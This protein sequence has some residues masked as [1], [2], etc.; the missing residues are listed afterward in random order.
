[1]A[2]G[3]PCFKTDQR[4]DR[5]KPFHPGRATV[6]VGLSQTLKMSDKQPE[7]DAE[8]NAPAEKTPLYQQAKV[9]DVF[10][11]ELHVVVYKGLSE[12]NT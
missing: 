11:W 12:G 5:Q 6:V 10:R 3:Q 8:G 1:M 4:T 7:L 9:G 2:T